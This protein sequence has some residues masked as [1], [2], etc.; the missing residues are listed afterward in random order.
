MDSEFERSEFEPPLYNFTWSP[1][2]QS[3]EASCTG[4]SDGTPGSSGKSGDPSWAD[5]N[6]TLRDTGWG[7][8]GEG[9]LEIANDFGS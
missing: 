3:G 5:G 6:G 9:N 7:F 1:P 2:L 8:D 4:M